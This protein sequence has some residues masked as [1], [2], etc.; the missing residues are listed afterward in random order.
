MMSY[1]IYSSEEISQMQ[2]E[3]ENSKMFHNSYSG[4]AR[5]LLT[6]LDILNQSELVEQNSMN[7]SK[8]LQYSKGLKRIPHS[9]C[10]VLI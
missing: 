1:L 8:Q 2:Q 10:E 6:L 3:A 4:D 7:R 9:N 5:F